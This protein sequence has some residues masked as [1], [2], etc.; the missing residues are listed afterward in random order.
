MPAALSVAGSY[1]VGGQSMDKWL[2]KEIEHIMG[3]NISTLSE[4]ASALR[5]TLEHEMERQ[6]KLAGSFVHIAGYEY[7]GRLWHPEFHFIRNVNGID[8]NTGKY[9]GVRERFAVSEEFWSTYRPECTPPSMYPNSITIQS[10][11]NGFPEGRIAYN[12]ANLYL[13]EFFKRVWGRGYFKYPSTLEEWSDLLHL[14]FNVIIYLF[15]VG[16]LPSMPVGGKLQSKVIALPS[17]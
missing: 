5:D 7:D 1:T 4:F 8:E 9:I 2:P 17:S 14:S 10:Y 16:S 6:E 13:S 3:K 11:F 12:E 15:G